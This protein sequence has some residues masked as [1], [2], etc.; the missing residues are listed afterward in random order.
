MV[1]RFRIT[2]DRML[3]RGIERPVRHR[4]ETKHGADVDDAATPLASH[5]GH[6]RARHPYDPEEVRIENRLGLFDRAFF[7]SAGGDTE[8][9]VVHEQV[10]AAFQAHHFPD[11][12]FDRFIARHVEGQ[13]RERSL[14]RLGL[15]SAGAVDLVA[16]RREPLRRGFTD[17]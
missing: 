16:S 15:P 6:D 12:G 2:F 11:G 10:D 13:H 8:A 4:Q 14:A 3:G 9:G 1:E 17:A 7:R 5:M